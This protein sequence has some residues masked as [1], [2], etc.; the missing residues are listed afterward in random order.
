M[1]CFKQ[2]SLVTVLQILFQTFE[3]FRQMRIYFAVGNHRR[4][5]L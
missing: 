4:R 5:P 2:R 3:D 1:N